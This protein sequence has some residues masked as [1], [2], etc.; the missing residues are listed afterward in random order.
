MKENTSHPPT[1]FTDQNQLGRIIRYIEPSTFREEIIT[2]VV[3]YFD[4]LLVNYY[5]LDNNFEGS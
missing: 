4:Q 1:R 5:N 3:F 2:I